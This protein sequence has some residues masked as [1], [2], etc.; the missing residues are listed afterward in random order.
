RR[1]NAAVGS[2]GYHETLTVAFTLLIR[3]RLATAEIRDGFPAFRARNRDLFDGRA[4]LFN[5]HYDPTTLAS[6]E[7]RRWFVEPDREP[8]P[9]AKL[10]VRIP[11]DVEPLTEEKS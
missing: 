11:P 6:A 8:L 5:R 10:A 9:G 1:Y 3:S 2:A 7:A 4:E